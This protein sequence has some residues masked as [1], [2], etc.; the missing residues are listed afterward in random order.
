MRSRDCWAAPPVYVVRQVSTV[1]AVAVAPCTW[2]CPQVRSSRSMRATPPSSRAWLVCF[3]SWKWATV[4]VSDMTDGLRAAIAWACSP[5][6]CSMTCR[7]VASTSPLLVAIPEAEP[8]ASCA[9]GGASGPA[10]R[11]PSS[12]WPR[13]PRRP[14]RAGAGRPRRRGRRAGASGARPPTPGGRPRPVRSRCPSRSRRA[15]GPASYEC[16]MPSSCGRAQ[17]ARQPRA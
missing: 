7:I 14:G 4:E 13:P 11:A 10:R 8:L 15:T 12:G 5:F 3:S 1:L 2:T 6:D 16:P 9:G 17:R